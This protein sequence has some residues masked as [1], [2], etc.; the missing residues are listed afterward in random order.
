MSGLYFPTGPNTLVNPIGKTS[1][2]SNLECYSLIFFFLLSYIGFRYITQSL[3]ILKDYIPF[4][5][6]IKCWLYSL[7]CII[8]SCG[9][10]YTQQFVPF[11]LLPQFCPSPHWKPL[12]WALYCM[13]LFVMFTRFFFRLVWLF[14][15]CFLGPHPWHMEVPTLGVKSELQL[16]AY[17]MAT[18]TQDP[19]CI[20]N[21]H[22]SSGQHQILNPLREARD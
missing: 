4:T 15:S 13:F 6:I 20:C 21:L 12:A 5:V 17:T 16:L 11:N 19:S 22:H 10:F 1:T 9:L 2:Q 3:T 8:Y 18:A 14:V 7:H